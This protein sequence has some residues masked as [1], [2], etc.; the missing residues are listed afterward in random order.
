MDHIVE[1]DDDNLLDEMNSQ[2]RSQIIDEDNLDSERKSLKISGKNI[3]N[4][5]NVKQKKE[6]K[7][8]HET[9]NNNKGIDYT[10]KAKSIEK[11]IIKYPVEHSNDFLVKEENR[12][13]IAP[14]TIVQ[15]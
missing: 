12:P 8:K 11:N 6:K 4:N 9:K 15:E 14:L 2:N 10:F 5:L 13:Y 7:E 1:N 3:L